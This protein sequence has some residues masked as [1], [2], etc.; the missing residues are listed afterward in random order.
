MIAF[1]MLHSKVGRIKVELDK[2]ERM[3]QDYLCIYR[4]EGPLTR[5]R[6]RVLGID[7]FQV[8]QMAMER[9]AADLRASAEFEAGA[10][11]WLDMDEPGFPLPAG[12]AD[13][14]WLSSDSGRG[15]PSE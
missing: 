10:L 15:T 5:K 4:I 3:Q 11:S 1:R 7:G 2:P 6:G 13:L 12:V 9:I 8:L 14:G